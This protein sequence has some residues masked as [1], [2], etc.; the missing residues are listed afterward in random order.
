MR[1]AV[2]ADDPIRAHLHELGMQARHLVVP[3]QRDIAR[4]PPADRDARALG[5]Q[6]EQLLA[7]LVVAVEKERRT[8]A[9]GAIVTCGSSGRDP[10]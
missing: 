10:T 2:V 1:E 3:G 8:L 5:W 6:L 7:P 4:R 9:H